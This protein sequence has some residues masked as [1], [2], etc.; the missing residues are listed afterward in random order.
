MEEQFINYQEIL[1]NFLHSGIYFLVGILVLFLGRKVYQMI[2]P[3]N[4]DEEISVKDNVAAGIT[5][6]G[7]YLAL[8]II[9]HASVGGESYFGKYDYGFLR[10]FAKDAILSVLYFVLGLIS[11]SVGRKILQLILPFSLDKEI[12]EDKNKAVA[13]VEASFY[14]TLAIIIHASFS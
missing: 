12:V 11:L 5:E 6:A 8:G 3:Y 9:I 7:F 14:L 10:T 1:I 4:I 2:T 13:L